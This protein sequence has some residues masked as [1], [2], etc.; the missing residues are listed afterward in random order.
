MIMDDEELI[1]DVT[2]AMLNL[3]G[4]DVIPARDGNEAV[5]LYQQYHDAGEP[6]DIIIMDLTIPGSMGGK[7][8]VREILAINPRARVIVSSG[9]SHDPV[10]AHC[11]EYGFVAAL[12]K[13]FL[14]QEINDVLNQILK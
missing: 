7:E 3:L 4:H 9:Y 5:K 8:A 14:L 2:S 6:I 1:R 13:P 12:V 11:Q 10:M